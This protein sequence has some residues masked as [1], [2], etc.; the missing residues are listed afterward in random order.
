MSVIELEFD[1]HKGY[2][3]V[4]LKGRKISKDD[5]MQLPIIQ[6]AVK[7]IGPI[8]TSEPGQILYGQGWEIYA[9]WQSYIGGIDRTPRVVLKLN[10]QVDQR[11]ITDFWMRFQ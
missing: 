7:N 8:L 1:I 9:D 10:R 4:V 2:T 3:D 6:W 11:L 5:Y